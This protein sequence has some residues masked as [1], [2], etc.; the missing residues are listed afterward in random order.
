MWYEH[1]V[2][3]HYLLVLRQESCFW[4]EACGW[5][6]VGHG[7]DVW[8]QFIGGNDLCYL[9]PFCVCGKGRYH[10]CIHAWYRVTFK[11]VIILYHPER[12]E[13]V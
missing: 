12:Y 5:Q 13:H 10:Q 4:M 8:G 9:Q 1:L 6:G 11:P 7:V 2:L 3:K